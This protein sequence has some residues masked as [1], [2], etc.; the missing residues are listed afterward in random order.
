MQVAAI[1][2]LRRLF[3][4]EINIFALK[5][6]AFGID[7]V[8]WAKSVFEVGDLGR[9]HLLPDPVNF[10]SYVD[11]LYY[12]VSQLQ[13]RAVELKTECERLKT[14]VLI[15][16]LGPIDRFQ[17]PPNFRCHL[18]GAGTSSAFHIDGDPKYG[19]AQNTINA[20]IP[21]TKVSGNNSIHIETRVGAGDFRPVNLEPGE[22]LL[23]DAFHLSHGSLP[24][25]TDCSRVSFEIRF[26]PRD[27][28]I[29]RKLGLYANRQ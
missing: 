20:W 9:I 4:N 28:S 15:P 13:E 14:E 26:V 12:R 17:F 25:D 8:A 27:V 3:G 2:R 29:G 16:L 22:L 6:D 19:V 5:Y 11:R 24:N 1:S 23:F 21:L 7:F 18:S 10:H